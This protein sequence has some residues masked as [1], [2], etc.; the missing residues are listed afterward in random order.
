MS[1]KKIRIQFINGLSFAQSPEE[2]FAPLLSE[3]EFIHEER[4]PEVLVF[5]PYGNNNPTGDYIRVGYFCENFKPDM[6]LCEYGFGVPYEEEIGH[7]NY[8]RID[9]HGFEPKTLIKSSEFAENTIKEKTHFCNFLYGN[10]V[11][12]REYFFRQLSKY[13][14]VDSPGKS[15]NNMPALISDQNQNFWLSKRNFIRKY[16]FTIAFENY[17]YP[18]YHT[19]KILDPM[20]IGSIPIYIGNPEISRHFNEDSFVHGRNYLQNHRDTFTRYI[21]NIS[22]PDFRDWRPGFYHSPWDKLKRKVKI[23]GR[24]Y[25]LNLEF[26]SGF[27]GLIE[28]II[29]LDK[30]DDAYYKMLQQP[31]Y[32]SNT[33]PDRSPFL[34]Q[35]R[36]IFNSV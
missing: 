29:A 14:K 13:K 33:P 10:Q 32:K 22:Q 34:N 6:R 18:G 26:R 28:R 36:K 5:G 12:Y 9:W 23:Y 3:Y 17:T 15:M 24:A 25:K 27:E 21:E 16:K 4:K 8:K 35:W 30:D 2:I 7:P 31:W 20:L 1:K 11:P 19:E